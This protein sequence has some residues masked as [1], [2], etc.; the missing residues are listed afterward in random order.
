MSALERARTRQY[1][2][3]GLKGYVRSDGVKIPGARNIYSG[4]Q[5]RDGFDLRHIE[6][7]SAAQ[8]RAARER[9]QSLNTLTSRPFTVLIPRTAKQKKAARS[10]TGQ[11]LKKQKEFIVTVQDTKRDKV[12]FQNNKV[13]IQREF[14]SGT[15]TIKQRYLFA[16]YLKL[17]E[18]RPLT[19]VQMRDI[20]KRMLPDMPDRYRGNRLYY[21]LIT[22]QYGPI[23]NSV[24]K[25]DV[26][27]LLANY[28]ERYDPGRQHEGFAEQVIG[29]QMVGTFGQAS[30]YQ[31]DRER[32]SAA[33][34]QRR[35]LRFTER[36]KVKR[37]QRVNKQGKRCVRESGH[38]G[39]HRFV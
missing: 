10:Y 9:V 12:T 36:N 26:L 4:L 19:F 5:A 23:G 1:I 24:W 30:Q 8:L 17:G 14:E 39:K 3:E 33:A 34:R 38:P 16:D 27:D 28:H 35:K 18:P 11:G 7:W 13:I 21:T 37:C 32:K 31:A 6:R 15:K 25:D 2:K 20:T 29:F 22:I